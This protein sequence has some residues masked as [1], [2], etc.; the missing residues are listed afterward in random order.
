MW[1]YAT[2]PYIPYITIH[3]HTYHMVHQISMCA[4]WCT[5][6]VALLAALLDRQQFNA[7]CG[8]GSLDPEFAGATK[9]SNMVPHY[10]SARQ[11][12]TPGLAQAAGTCIESWSDSWP[13]KRTALQLSTAQLC[14]RAAVLLHQQDYLSRT[15]YRMP[16]LHVQVIQ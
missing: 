4:T 12:D 10:V 8:T 3:A 9:Q 1:V 2:C 14:N 16:A 7:W 5:K 11:C 15:Q 6:V 13:T